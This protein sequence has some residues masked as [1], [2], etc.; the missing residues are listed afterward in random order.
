MYL[1]AGSALCRM[2]CLHTHT[3]CCS[4]AGSLLGTFSSLGAASSHLFNSH[5][6]SS[7]AENHF[8][9][10][11]AQLWDDGSGCAQHA[12]VWHSVHPPSFP[13]GNICQICSFLV[14]E[15]RTAICILNTGVF[16]CFLL[17]VLAL[18]V[19]RNMVSCVCA[20]LRKWGTHFWTFSLN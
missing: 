18:S 12:S 7:W 14:Q 13:L 4:G 1:M 15:H 9:A 6:V 8:V 20:H 2:L 19:Q 10:C 3:V 16:W 5:G 11:W 17:C